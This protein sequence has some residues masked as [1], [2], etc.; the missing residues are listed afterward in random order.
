MNLAGF[1]NETIWIIG[2]STGIGHALAHSLARQGAN[3]I[4]SARR[5]D[6]LIT[7]QEELR[8]LTHDERLSLSTQTHASPGEVGQGTPSRPVYHVCPMD[9]TDLDSSARAVKWCEDHVGR[10]D[11]ILFLPATHQ[12]MSLRNLDLHAVDRIIK[13]N[14]T[15][16]FYFLKSIESWLTPLDSKTPNLK[17]LAFCASVA[18]YN[19]LRKGQPYCSTKAAMINVLQGLRVELWGQVDVKVIN[20]GFVKTPLTDN[21]SYPMPMIITASEAATRISKGLQKKGFEIHFPK[22]FTYI[23]KVLAVLPYSVYFWIL[24]KTVK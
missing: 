17:Q 21:S 6:L 18:G 9:V 12:A 24:R 23:L 4:L 20:P 7:L 22:A 16:V 15:S 10:V 14:Y 19:G 2:A 8:G 13:V 11:R 3:L 5:E 1:K